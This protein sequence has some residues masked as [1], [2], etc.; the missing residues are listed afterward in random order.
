MRRILLIFLSCGSFVLSESANAQWWGTANIQYPNVTV[1]FDGDIATVTFNG[2]TTYGFDSDSWGS[3]TRTSS[4]IYV[5]DGF[6]TYP[7]LQLYDSTVNETARMRLSESSSS[8]TSYSG[9]T[10]YPEDPDPPPPDTDNPDTATAEDLLRS[11]G[12][13]EVEVWG[14]NSEGEWELLTTMAVDENGAGTGVWNDEWNDMELRY[15]LT[16]VLIEGEMSQLGTPI[17]M[18]QGGGLSK[19]DGASFSAVEL[20]RNAVNAPAPGGTPSAL[21]SFSPSPVSLPTPSPI[22]AGDDAFPLTVSGTTPTASTTE[23]MSAQTVAEGVK[24]ALDSYDVDDVPSFEYD[25]TEPPADPGEELAGGEALGDLA[26]A[27]NRLA[28]ATDGFLSALQGLTATLVLTFP[29]SSGSSDVSWSFEALGETYTIRPPPE[30]WSVTRALARLV[31][32]ALA[33]GGAYG[34]VRYFIS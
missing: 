20:G 23:S 8:H 34:V 16:G 27:E 6:S 11:S 3:Y 19:D 9:Y 33:V 15:D 28:A 12:G 31:Y 22:V 17:T 7:R 26:D 1:V 13:G 18:G 21:P 30:F 24:A 29:S 2:G 25:T 4:H 14:R 5:R 32:S 10:L